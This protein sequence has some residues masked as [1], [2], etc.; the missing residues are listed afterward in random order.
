MSGQS[1]SHATDVADGAAPSDRP[2]YTVIENV[3]GRTH[4]L[5]CPDYVA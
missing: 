3:K 4:P 2:A 1:S 5:T